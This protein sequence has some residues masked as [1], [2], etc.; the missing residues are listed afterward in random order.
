M[1]RKTKKNDLSSQNFDGSFCHVGIVVSRFHNDVTG[2]L[3]EGALEILRKNR[4]K[5]ENIKVIFVPG[6][7]EIPFACTFLARSKKYHA[8]IALGCVIKGKTDHYQ[9]IASETTRGIMNVMLQYNIP[10][11][12]GVLTVDTLSKAEERAGKKCNWGEK[13]ALA[14]L[15]LALLSSEK[16]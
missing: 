6:S 11:G 13:A 12:F 16:S 2:K 14:A 10:V 15:E 7:F 5:E 4:V 8:L 9:Y 1:Q 3:L